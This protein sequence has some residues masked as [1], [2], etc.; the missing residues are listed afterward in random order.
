MWC[1]TPDDSSGKLLSL[2][3][4]APTREVGEQGW[5]G[6][7]CQERFQDSTRRGSTHIGHDRGELDVGV[8]QDRLQPIGQAS[9]LLIDPAHTAVR[10]RE[11][12]GAPADA[13]PEEQIA[14]LDAPRLA[15]LL[16]REF[17][18]ALINNQNITPLQAAELIR[19]GEAEA[20]AYGRQFIANPD[21]PARLARG[22][23][24]NEPNPAS[25][26]HFEHPADG[27]TDYPKLAV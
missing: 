8:F 21:L 14:A 10:L 19:R 15:P 24:L 5:V 7:S 3:P 9:T 23:A 25:F 6:F 22:A 1:E 2:A 16:K 11:G 12:L 17:G 20:I 18:G 26:Y 4:Q 13:T 27:Y